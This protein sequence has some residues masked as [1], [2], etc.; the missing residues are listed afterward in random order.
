MQLIGQEN[1]ESNKKNGGYVGKWHA[2]SRA[3][4]VFGSEKYF[5]FL[6]KSLESLL[7]TAKRKIFIWKIIRNW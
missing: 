2:M 5:G 6:V 1:R 3:L 7:N 4:G